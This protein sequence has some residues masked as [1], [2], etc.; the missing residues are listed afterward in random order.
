[1]VVLQEG[2]R[3]SAALPVHER[4]LGQ[5]L[6]RLTAARTDRQAVHPPGVAATTASIFRLAL[7]RPVP[8]VA[9]TQLEAT[10]DTTVLAPAP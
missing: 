8:G 4:L 7:E 3:R 9:A 2:R 10:V 5:K 6:L 1:M